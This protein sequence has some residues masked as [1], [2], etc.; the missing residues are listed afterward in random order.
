M[1]KDPLHFKCN[2]VVSF[3]HVRSKFFLINTIK[4]EMRITYYLKI[5]NKKK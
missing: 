3:K 1:D 4:K 2:K 5:K